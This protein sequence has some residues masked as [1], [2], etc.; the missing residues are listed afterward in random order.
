MQTSPAPITIRNALQTSEEGVRR[1]LTRRQPH[2]RRR[3]AVELLSQ[4]ARQGTPRLNADATL[5][6]MDKNRNLHSG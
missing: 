3:V 6:P 1:V 4:H 5:V 2:N